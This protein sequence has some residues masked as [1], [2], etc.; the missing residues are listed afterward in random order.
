MAA[1]ALLGPGCGGLAG[2]LHG[3][4][5]PGGA[6]LGDHPYELTIEF[7]DVLEL[8]P[9]S[10]VKVNDVPVGSVTGI[11]VGPDLTALVTVRVNRE[12][13][14]PADA[15]AR[16]RT[17][18][19]LG[20]KFVELVAPQ[21]GGPA[22][23]QIADGATIPLARTSRAA[24]VEEV[25]GALSLLLNGVGQIR[26]IATELNTALAGN[27][28]E[29]KSTLRRFATLM[30]GLDDGEAGIVRPWRTSTPWPSRSTRRPTP[31]TWR[32][33]AA[34]GHRVRRQPARGPRQDAPGAPPTSAASAPRS[35]RPRSR[36]RSSRSRRWRRC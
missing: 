11:E 4:D 23:P 33:R 3:V 30:E 16:V 27:E 14:V 31:S 22:A 7:T 17:T 21:A 1:V 18:S 32:W 34:L 36:A 24:E 26:T 19:L 25:L 9:Q 28:E 35:S 15:L 12:V 20:E 6:D 29:V 10:L 8:V 2:G 13:R 5:L